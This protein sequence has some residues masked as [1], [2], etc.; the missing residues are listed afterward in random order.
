MDGNFKR[1]KIYR[2]RQTKK[3]MKIVKGMKKDLPERANRNYERVKT[4]VTSSEFIAFC[5]R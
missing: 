4:N 1:K 3:K 5:S 2:Y